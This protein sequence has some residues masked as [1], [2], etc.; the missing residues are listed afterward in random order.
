MD[1]QI[2]IEGV[3]G[4]GGVVAGRMIQA[5]YQPTLITSNPA[6]TEAIQ[7]EGIRITSPEGAAVVKARAYTYLSDLPDDAAFDVAYLI[8]KAGS[9][10][11]AAEET[12]PNL[13]PQG[14]VVTCQNGVVEDAVGQVV[15]PERLVSAIMGWGGTMHA[16]GVY[17]RTS[18]GATHIGEMDG[19][20]T[21]R[22]QMMKRHLETAAPVV[23]STNQ[24]GKLWA[25][26]AINCTITTI[27]ALTGELLG[28]M[29]KDARVRRAF[30][31][32]YAEVIDTALALGVQPE[33]IAADPMT[34]YA[35]QD[36]G[37]LTRFAKDLMVRF[38]A[39]KYGRLKSSS[40]QSLERGRLTEIDYLN[41]YVVEQA[42]AV[43]VPTPLNARLVTLIKDIEQGRRQISPDNLDALLEALV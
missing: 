15:G 31:R 13:A 32:A 9:V 3:G 23:I 17:E 38:V 16:P 11:A 10:V 35:P 1:E 19:R 21:D 43:G 7:K 27:G 18:T 37:A 25:K 6:I 4:I 36:A 39:R 33:A 20:L 5:G 28:D 14:F 8:M 40:L 24:R 42:K 34:L 29:L 26:L 30:L 2:L 12:L 41:G 22:L